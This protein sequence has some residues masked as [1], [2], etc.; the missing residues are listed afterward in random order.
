MSPTGRD[1]QPVATGWQSCPA[2]HT[3]ICLLPRHTQNHLPPPFTHTPHNHR[4]QPKNP[5]SWLNTNQT[6]PIAQHKWL[7]PG[8]PKR[9][10]QLLCYD[11]NEVELTLREVNFSLA[12]QG[13]QSN[14]KKKIEKIK[15]LKKYEILLNKNDSWI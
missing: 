2:Y 5:E 8:I 13:Q 4:P 11:I 6:D 12:S 1:N 10:N 9:R 3:H 15:I 7:S 14:N